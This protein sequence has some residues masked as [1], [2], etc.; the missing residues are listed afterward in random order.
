MLKKVLILM[1]MV[2]LI[3]FT[4]CEKE[5]PAEKMGKK[6][7]NAVEKAGDQVQKAGDAIE[8]KTD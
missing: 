6:I 1:A 8:K 7:D 3:G 5:G 4:A 2:A